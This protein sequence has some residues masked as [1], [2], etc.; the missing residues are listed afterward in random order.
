[1]K[2]SK[3][4]VAHLANR[5][6][7]KLCSAFDSKFKQ[8][9]FF[10]TVD[11]HHHHHHHHHNNHH[12]NHHHNN[13]DDNKNSALRASLCTDPRT[14]PFCCYLVPDG[15]NGRNVEHAFPSGISVYRISIWW[16]EGTLERENSRINKIK[17]KSLPRPGFA[18]S[19]LHRPPKEH[20]ISAVP[21]RLTYE[22]RFNSPI[23]VPLYGEYVRDF[24]LRGKR[25]GGGFGLCDIS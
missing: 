9:K 25:G 19:K 18:F 5:L 11:R 4:R 17:I 7:W 15:K 14:P 16:K 20:F 8:K 24:K 6:D 13:D 1:M 12:N 3:T 21:H 10:F 2:F 23:K 22:L